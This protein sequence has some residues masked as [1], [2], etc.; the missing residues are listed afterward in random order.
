MADLYP[1][2]FRFEQRDQ[3]GR[4]WC[5]ECPLPRRNAIHDMPEPPPDRSA[6]IQGEHDD[7]GEA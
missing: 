5:A 3:L 2:P 7:E 4:E 1:H 6:A